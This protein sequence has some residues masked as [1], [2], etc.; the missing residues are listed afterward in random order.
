[1]KTSGTERELDGRIIL[2]RNRSTGWAFLALGYLN[3]LTLVLGGE[4]NVINLGLVPLVD[5]SDRLRRTR[6]PYSNVTK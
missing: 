2:H 6:Q 4:L 1:M 3:F 5:L